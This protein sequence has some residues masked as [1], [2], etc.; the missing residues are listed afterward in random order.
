MQHDIFRSGYDLD[1][2]SSFQGD[3]LMSNYNSLDAS[4]QEKRDAGKMIFVPLLSQ[5]LSQKTFIQKQLFFSCFLSLE[6]KPLSLA[7]IW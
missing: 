7:E 3:L 1:L 6:A 2:R 4:Q 5:K